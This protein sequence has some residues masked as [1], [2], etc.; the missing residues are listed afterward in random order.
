MMKK[1]VA[2]QEGKSLSGI[3]YRR[4]CLQMIPVILK[5][6]MDDPN[7]FLYLSP[8]IPSSPRDR[9]SKQ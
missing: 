2:T 6:I 9:L 5:I 8:C 1:T 7:D 4:G 3:W